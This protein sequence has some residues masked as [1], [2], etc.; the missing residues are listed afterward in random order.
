[1]PSTVMSNSQLRT[2]KRCRRKYWLTYVRKLQPHWYEFTGARRLGTRVHLALEVFYSPGTPPAARLGLALA[3][4]DGLRDEELEELAG[5][6]DRQ[7]D[8]L[9]EHDLAVAMVEG[10]AQWVE[11]E[12]VDTDIEPIATEQLVRAPSPVEG[13]ELIGKLDLLFR[14]ISTGVVG[15][16]DFKTVGDLQ[17]PL[18]TLGMDEQFRMYALMQRLIAAHDT[19]NHVRSQLYRMLK[20]SKRT[21]RAKPPF[22]AEYEVY[23]SDAELR[24]MWDRLY[25]EITDIL[26]FERR[27]DAAPHQ[28][29]ML[30]YP[31]P[32]NDCSW[33]CDF[34]GV[35]PL[36]DD[37][38][39][40]PEHVL[41]MT[42]VVG[43]P[44]AHYGRQLSSAEPEAE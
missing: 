7:T 2:W 8:V 32:T 33:D 35:C 25:G 6:P 18:K 13:V 44:H 16:L 9:K 38:H 15:F 42:Y 14:R 1:M 11:E 29:R 39:A 5:D 26:E 17:S 41:A 37:D 31:N 28:H 21:A 43:D 27:I 12:G 24:A 10:Y 30:A 36:F 3:A 22:F 19:H 4:L 34:H 20:K 40:D 23:I